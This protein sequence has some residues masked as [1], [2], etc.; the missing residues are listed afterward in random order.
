MTETEEREVWREFGESPS[1]RL[2]SSLRRSERE[3]QREQ[4]PRAREG[5]RQEQSERVAEG[6]R[7]R[8][9]RDADRREAVGPSQPASSRVSGPCNDTMGCVVNSTGTELF[10][11]LEALRSAAAQLPQLCQLAENKKVR[12]AITILC[13]LDIYNLQ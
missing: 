11:Q 7:D 6:E 13:E 2:V 12:Q 1:V 5:E 4:A 8:Q 10:L 3:G 9:T